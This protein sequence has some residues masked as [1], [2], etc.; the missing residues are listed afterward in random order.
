AGPRPVQT[1]LLLIR[2]PSVMAQIPTGLP[3]ISTEHV[4][5][6]A[7]QVPQDERGA[8]PYYDPVEVHQIA[9]SVFGPEPAWA[10]I[11]PGVRAA[12]EP[13]KVPMLTTDW[14]NIIDLD[15]WVTPRTGFV[16]QRPV[17]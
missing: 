11:G 10:P 9:R 8:A 15:A 1:D 2:H 16:S 13:S 3:P 4:L 17:I 14:E 7:N 6:V 5:L 12:L